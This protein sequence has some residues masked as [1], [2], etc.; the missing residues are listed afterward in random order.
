M[1]APLHGSHFAIIPKRTME[2]GGGG[3]VYKI[4]NYLVANATLFNFFFTEYILHTV[5]LLGGLHGGVDVRWVWWLA[6]FGAALT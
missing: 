5:V 2:G 6:C 1:I 3:L 4:C